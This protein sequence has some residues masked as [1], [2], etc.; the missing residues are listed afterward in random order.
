MTR[1]TIA[2][3]LIAWPSA[4]LAQNALIAGHPWPCH[5]I[6]DSSEGADG[7]RLADVNSDGLQDIV[8]GWEEGGITRVYINP[9]P[10][11]VT[12]KWPAVTVGR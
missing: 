2:L 4:C 7:V 5:V 11:K 6:D 8:T 1:C 10:D 3:F 12:A 9:G